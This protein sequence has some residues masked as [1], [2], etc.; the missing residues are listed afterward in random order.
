MTPLRRMLLLIGSPKPSRSASEA[1]G[2]SLLDRLAERGVQTDT[3]HVH[4]AVRSADGI[5]RLLAATDSAELVVLA[6]PLYVDSLPAPVIKALELIAQHRQ[7]VGR[8]EGQWLLPISNSGFPEPT[9]N[10]SALAICRQFAREAG[11]R[12]AGGLGVGG[13]GLVVGRSLAKPGGMVR[14]IVQALDLTAA[15]LADGQPVPEAAYS[16]LATPIVWPWLY[17]LIGNLGFRR[18]ARKSRVDVRAR[19]HQL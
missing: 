18:E 14:P 13:G 15:A 8:P 2:S 4:R 3:V 12:W 1:L 11:F 7:Q 9:Q 16:L 5:A 17:R 10:D 6:F 19:P